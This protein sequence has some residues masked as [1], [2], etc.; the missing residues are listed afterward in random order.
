MRRGELNPGCVPPNLKQGTPSSMC[1]HEITAHFTVADMAQK[2]DIRKN[3][4]CWGQDY[5]KNHQ[6]IPNKIFSFN[7]VLNP[8]E[9][10]WSMLRDTVTLRRA[11]AWSFTMQTLASFCVLTI[12]HMEKPTRS[13]TACFLCFAI[14]TIAQV[15]DE[16]GYLAIPPC[17][18]GTEEEGLIAPVFL[19]FN[20]NLTSIKRNNNTYTH[21]GEMASWQMRGILAD[22]PI[23]VWN[24]SYLMSC[25]LCNYILIN[26]K[27]SKSLANGD[28]GF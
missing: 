6:V 18:W 22:L 16:L 24:M 17:I 23:D 21:Y 26:V 12:Q 10:I 3:P 2:C 27:L 13:S 20:A 1:T 28:A 11:S 4:G 19:P 9:S 7:F 5:D 14:G 25:D 15:F 8:R